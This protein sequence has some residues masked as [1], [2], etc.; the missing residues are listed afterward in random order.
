MTVSDHNHVGV[1]KL[2]G[3]L[4]VELSSGAAQMAAAL[5]DAGVAEG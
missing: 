3:R 2:Q 4:L 5:Q 1:E